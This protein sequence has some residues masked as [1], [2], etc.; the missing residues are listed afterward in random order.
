MP[1]SPLTPGWPFL[2]G[3]PCTG[4]CKL[5]HSLSAFNKLL[6]ALWPD[7]GPPLWVAHLQDPVGLLYT[8]WILASN[9]WLLHAS[10]YDQ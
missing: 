9:G 6:A 4:G 2:F 8:C 1:V 5:F 3:T 10:W 7:E